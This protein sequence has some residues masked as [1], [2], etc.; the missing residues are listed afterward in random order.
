MATKALYFKKK[1]RVKRILR[2]V[3]FFFGIFVE[4]CEVHRVIHVLKLHETQEKQ[5]DLQ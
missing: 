3:L 2:E 5:S 4:G 1:A